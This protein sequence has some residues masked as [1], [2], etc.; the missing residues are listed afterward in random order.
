MKQSEVP[1]VR[2]TLFK[3]LYT[4]WCYYHGDDLWLS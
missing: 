4:V 3:E 1:Q 2:E